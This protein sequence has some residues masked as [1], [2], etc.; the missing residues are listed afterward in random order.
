MA[1]RTGAHKATIPNLYA[2]QDKRTGKIYWQ[3]KQPLT[4]RFHSLGVCMTEAIQIASEA[5][6]IFADQ[7]A[8]QL[9]R[10]DDNLSQ[11]FTLPEDTTVTEWLERYRVIQQERMAAG[12]LK[13]ATLKQKLN[14]LKVFTEHFGGLLLNNI[15]A[16]HITQIM[17]ATRQDGRVRQA[18]V[19]RMVLVDVFKEAQ[20][21]GIVPPGFNPA[22]VTR[23]P[24]HKVQR[25]RLNLEEWQTIFRQAQSLQPYLRRGMLLAIVTGQR[26]GDICKM[27]FSD[28]W[29]GYLHIIQQKT[30]SKVAIPLSLHCSALVISLEDVILECRDALK[31]EYLIHYLRNTSQVSPGDPITT[32]NLTMLFSQARDNCGLSWPKKAAPT[33]HEQR[34]LAERLYSEQ[35]VNTQKLLG[36]KS[37]AMTDKYHDDRGKDWVMV[38]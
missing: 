13:P 20:H 15:T 24:H 22:K 32:S 6:V 11:A 34:S 29:D 38:G 35:G 5:N 1:A 12:E 25:Q 31:S 10:S 30:G 4:G 33:F 23:L 9:L 7:K 3:Y 21:N 8:R 14:P 26:I 27:K 36:H 37:Q 18:Q 16:L 17:D 2:K 19:F 28:I